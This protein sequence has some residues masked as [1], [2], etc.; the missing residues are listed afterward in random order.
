MI[1]VSRI[2]PE[3]AMTKVDGVIL[4]QRARKYLEGFYGLHPDKNDLEAAHVIL[5][6][7]ENELIGE[8][9]LDP[10]FRGVADVQAS[11]AL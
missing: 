6:P 5:L 9:A 8:L 11:T 2:A 10:R 3:G 4:L 1:G 7:L